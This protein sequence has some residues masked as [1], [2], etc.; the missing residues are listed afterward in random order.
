MAI[1]TP[2]VLSSGRLTERRGSPMDREAQARKA[3]EFNVCRLLEAAPKC[4]PAVLSRFGSRTG[5]RRPK[6]KASR[7]YRS[8]RRSGSTR[9]RIG[10]RSRHSN[11][12]DAP[13]ALGDFRD[14]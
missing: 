7:A 8:L 5:E 6:A 2:A 14:S 9:L 13:C 11:A 4:T 12:F 3:G 10:L 1:E